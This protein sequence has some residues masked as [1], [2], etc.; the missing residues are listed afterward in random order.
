M[1]ETQSMVINK[2]AKFA[3]EMEEG[4]PEFLFCHT[5]YQIGFALV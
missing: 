4:D 3:W 1:I 2:V 5:G